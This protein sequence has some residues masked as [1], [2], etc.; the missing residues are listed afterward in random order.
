MK[1]KQRKRWKTTI[2]RNIRIRDLKKKEV[3]KRRKGD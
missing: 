1:I 2:A 3:V